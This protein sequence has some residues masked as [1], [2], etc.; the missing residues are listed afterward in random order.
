[1]RAQKRRCLPAWVAL[2]GA[3]SFIITADT[4]SASVWSLPAPTIL[5]PGRTLAPVGTGAHGSV[6]R[7]VAGCR[8]AARS[9]VACRPCRPTRTQLCSGATPPLMVAG[10]PMAGFLAALRQRLR[11]D[12]ARVGGGRGEEGAL[13]QDEAGIPEVYDVRLDGSNARRVLWDA[14]RERLVAAPPQTVDGVQGV[15]VSDNEFTR[16]ARKASILTLVRHPSQAVAYAV[17]QGKQALLPRGVTQDYYAFTLWRMAQRIVSS[18]VS[19]FGT[20][21]LLL[22]LGVKTNKVRGRLQRVQVFETNLSRHTRWAR[23]RRRGGY[24]RMRWESLAR[25]R[26]RRVMGAPSTQ[27]LSDGA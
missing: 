13:L 18:S 15:E 10:V 19:V 23:R 6:Q 27:T 2:A 14:R 8:G 24:G 11:G 5:G 12:A 17:E 3:V 21:S 25:R 26:L 7:N 20:Q 4:F 16:S 9:R 1:M 22:A